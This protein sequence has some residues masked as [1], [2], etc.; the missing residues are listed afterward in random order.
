MVLHH[1]VEVH[2]SGGYS[3][4]SVISEEAQKDGDTPIF[5]SS[6]TGYQEQQDA[7]AFI[8]FL[9]ELNDL[10]QIDLEM[11]TWIFECED[12]GPGLYQVR[13]QIRDQITHISGT[14]IPEP[15]L[16]P[17]ST[18]TGFPQMVQ[19]SNNA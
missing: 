2:P 8:D 14:G 7:F 12:R 18:P 19:E 16:L 1:D 6:G 11:A 9:L 3:F 4:T 10:P 15:R 17:T 13:Y 5:Y